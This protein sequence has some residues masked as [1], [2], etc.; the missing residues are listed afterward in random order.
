MKLM[1]FT[2]GLMLGALVGGGLVLLLAPKS[3]AQTRTFV[4]NW[5]E[6]V[7]KEGQQAAESRRLELMTRLEELQSQ[8]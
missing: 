7:W 8:G 5:L 4:Q 3:G 2:E 1:R 6:A